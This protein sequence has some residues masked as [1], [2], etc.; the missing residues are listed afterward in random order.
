ME[1]CDQNKWTENNEQIDEQSNNK[2]IDLKT[3]I[4]IITLNINNLNAPV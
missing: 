3:N 4:L 1:E 2:M